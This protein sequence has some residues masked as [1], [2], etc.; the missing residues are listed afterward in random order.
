MLTLLSQALFPALAHS[1]TSPQF[2]LDQLHLLPVVTNSLQ[3]FHP[4]PE[5]SRKLTTC[6]HEKTVQ[7]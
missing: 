5:F 7:V 6:E 2:T 1:K 4:L 3:H